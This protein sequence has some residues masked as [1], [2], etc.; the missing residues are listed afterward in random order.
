MCYIGN[1][2]RMVFKNAHPAAGSA[3]R[4]GGVSPTHRA[5]VALVALALIAA[6]AQLTAQSAQGL[7]VVPIVRGD[8]L[9]VNVELREGLTPDVRAAID[10]GLKTIFTYT[11][12]LRL[13]V[14]GWLDRTVATSVVTNSVAFDNLE[15]IHTLERRIDGRYDRSETTMDA[16]K[17]RQWMTNLKDLPLFSTRVL[18]QNREYYVRVSATARPSYGSIL[19]PFG[20]GT[21]AQTKFVFFR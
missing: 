3:G 9:V 14:P 17:V 21:S 15:R 19:W 5:R 11:I 6:A 10:S 4:R 16:A 7:S 13:D 2:T 1:P 18:Q 8:H 12:E 20:S